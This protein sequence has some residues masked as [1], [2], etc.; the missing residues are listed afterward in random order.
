MSDTPDVQ[1]KITQSMNAM[2]LLNSSCQAIVETYIAP[3]ASPWYQQVENELGDAQ[4]LVRK[5]R[6]SGYLYFSQTILSGTA[7]C[8]S[9]ILASKDQIESLYTQLTTTYSPSLK[10]SL[11][12]QL[13]GF[14]SQ[15]SAL[16]N[17]IDDYEAKLKAWTL[18][19]SAVQNRLTTTVGAI[20]AQEADLQADIKSTND[21]I[22]SMQKTIETDRQAIAKAKAQRKRG[23]FETIFGCVLAP[24]TGGASLILAGIGV[25]SIVEGE[26]AVNALE[27]QIQTAT[28]HIIADQAHLTDDQKQIVSLQGIVASAN[29]LQ[30]DVDFIG[31]SLD[32]LRTD[33]QLLSD[34][35][36]DQISKITNA[37]NAQALIISKVWFDAS[38]E[39]WSSILDFANSLQ[40][41]SVSTTHVS[42]GSQSQALKA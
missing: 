35:L 34:N 1:G 18:Q 2:L 6:E 15:I 23:I 20:Q 30:S 38:C 28:S 3:S 14:G 9:S 5:W 33:W 19:I 4:D 40:N 17:N 42:I 8:A 21:Q 24:F 39:E 31:T 7:A 41:M 25:A 32:S 11:I 27:S 10:Q 22:A 13:S 16:N 26:A 29:L 12:S 37:E 36:T